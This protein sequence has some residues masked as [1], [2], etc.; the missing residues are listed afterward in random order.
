VDDTVPPEEL[1]RLIEEELRARE[2]G[3]DVK[4]EVSGDGER[5][6]VRVQVKKEL[7]EGEAPPK[8]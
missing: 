7:Q 2:P 1:K 6:E 8:P 4:V 5:R 3:A